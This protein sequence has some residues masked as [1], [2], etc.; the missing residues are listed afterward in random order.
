M[1]TALAERP[2]GAVS[3]KSAQQSDKKKEEILYLRQRFDA[4][5]ASTERSSYES[6]CEEIAALVSPRKIGFTGARTKGQKTMNKVYDPIGIQANELH[7][8]G[9]HGLATNPASQWFSLRM[10]GKTIIVQT[11]PGGQPTEYDLTDDK[12]VRKYLSDVEGVLWQ[13]IYQPGTNFT[14]ALHEFYLDLGAFGTA[15]MFVGERDNGGLLFETRSIAECVI[16]ENVDGRVDTVFRVTEYTVRQMLQMEKR[17]WTISQRIRDLATARKMD[18]PVK[19]IHAVYPRE[20]RDYTAKGQQDMPF[21]SIYFEHEACQV[22]KE[23]GFPEFPY[24]V[25]RWSKYAGE[26]YG[27]SPA[28]TALPDIKMLQSMDITK[29]KLLQKAADP[30]MWLRDDGVMGGTRTMPGGINYWRGNPSDGVMM[31][32]VSLEGL[33]VMLEDQNMIRQR[34]LKT[35]F[36]DML[37]MPEKVDMTATEYMQRVSERMR[38]LGPLIGRLES[39]ALGPLV[40][41]LFGMLSRRPG[42]LPKAPPIIVDQEFSVEYVSPIATAQKQL[43]ANSLVQVSGVLL[44]MLGEEGAAKVLGGKLD[45][46]KLIDYLWDL[47]NADPDLLVDEE[48]V[49]QRA[50]MEQLMQSLPAGVSIADIVQKLTAGAKNLGGTAQALGKTQVEGG[51]DVGAAV[52]AA[53]QGAAKSPAGQQAVQQLRD[54]GALNGSE[55]LA[56]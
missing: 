10:V 20:E 12:D 44:Q 33:R 4:L 46:E 38:L 14:T 8:A 28:M 11:E 9:L 43:E 37:Q 18:E 22:L 7:A 41:R 40:E 15:I 25:A 21:A 23:G 3:Q 53:A 16:D 55:A 27:R 19:V 49:E 29:I 54:T 1:A 35:F 50:M 13:R 32:P 17:G 52:S 51:L 36:A 47:F 31:Q 48:E 34:I 39:E 6:H 42:I 24:L 45:P 2:Y 56:A 30:P 5:K 26:V